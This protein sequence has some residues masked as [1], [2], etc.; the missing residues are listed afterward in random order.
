MFW[1]K[2]NLVSV[3]QFGPG[4]VGPVYFWTVQHTF[5]FDV[6]CFVSPSD[7]LVTLKHFSRQFLHLHILPTEL[8]RPAPLQCNGNQNIKGKK[9][10]ERA[11]HVTAQ[12]AQTGHGGAG[13]QAVLIEGL[14]RK[15]SVS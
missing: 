6:S 4:G 14:C 10:R 15:A 5:G 11:A 3:S 1:E 7:L 8:Q 9:A 12:V 2:H 13:R